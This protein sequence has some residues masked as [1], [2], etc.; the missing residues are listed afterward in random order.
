[1][2]TPSVRVNCPGK[3]RPRSVP[4]LVHNPVNIGLAVGICQDCFENYGL[5]DKNKPSQNTGLFSD[6]MRA[7]H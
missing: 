1:M 4:L 5:S 2:S 7:G 3:S 6:F